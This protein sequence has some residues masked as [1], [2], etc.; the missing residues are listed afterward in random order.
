LG[1]ILAALLFTGIQEK[2]MRLSAGKAAGAGNTGAIGGGGTMKTKIIMVGG[3]LGAGKTTLLG[4]LASRLGTD[5]IPLGLITND[6]ASELV[7]TSLLRHTGSVTEEV[8]GSCFCCNF[9][10][11]ADAIASLQKKGVRYIAAEP[12]G[13]CT[14]LSATVMQPLKEKMAASLEVSPLNVLADA[15][16]LSAIMAGETGGLHP[17]AV[18]ILKKQLEEADYILI[19]KA[20]LL[21]DGELKQLRSEAER[22]YPQA[23]VYVIS[24]LNGTG[25]G[26][27]MNTMLQ[28][29]AAGKTIT[30]V[31][32]DVYAE[33]EAVLGWLNTTVLLKNNGMTGTWKDFLQR[34]LAELSRKIDGLDAAVGHV[35]SIIQSADDFVIGNVTGRGNTLVIRGE[36]AA[37][38]EAQLVLNARAE[39]SP[40]RL[41][42]MTAKPSRRS[43][44]AR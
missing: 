32:Y 2:L 43:A 39:M 10:G 15:R 18:Y 20:D 35:K 4:Q 41:E 42:D 11:F 27:W 1:G 5:A 8:S 6:Q 34:L 9:Q 7:D 44:A 23:K 19:N 37:S 25:V 38:P 24:A 40:R 17:S 33:G 36:G 29:S 16:R 3:F 13:S 28:D 31:D 12:V 22:A 30:E 26:E 21:G 14:D